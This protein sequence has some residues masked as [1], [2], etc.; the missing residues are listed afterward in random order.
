MST[1]LPRIEKPLSPGARRELVKLARQA[2]QAYVL[3]E[4]P[5]RPEITQ[6]ELL[7]PRGAFV[8]LREQ[9]QLRGCIGTLE[10]E[11]P[12][13]E[14]VI[15]MAGAAALRDPRFL[16]V[17]PEELE[18]IEIEI[19][20]LTPFVE[21]TDVNDIVIGVH[22]LHVRQG[23]RAGLLL[24]QVAVEWGWNREE[25]LRQTCRKAGLPPDAWQRGAEIRAFSADIIEEKEAEDPDQ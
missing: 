15:E 20:V 12:L 22:G 8:T 17:T 7:E 14:T 23:G 13:Y 1:A 2:L 11:R 3:G 4:P 16:P 5:P 6:P 10:T 18:D 25:F 21:V 19:S 24:P 9:G